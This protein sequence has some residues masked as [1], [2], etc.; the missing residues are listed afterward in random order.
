MSSSV[1]NSAASSNYHAMGNVESYPSNARF[2]P[3]D[4]DKSLSE[5]DSLNEDKNLLLLDLQELTK[6]KSQREEPLEKMSLKLEAAQLLGG[7]LV[8]AVNIFGFPIGDLG[9]PLVKAYIF[10]NIMWKV[11]SAFAYVHGC[12]KESINIRRQ[13]ILTPI[14]VQ[15]NFALKRVA[16]IGIAMSSQLPPTLGAP[17]TLSFGGV[18]AFTGEAFF[19]MQS[20]RLLIKDS[21]RLWYWD[22]WWGRG[23]SSKANQICLRQ[24]FSAAIQRQKENFESWDVQ[25]RLQFI[26]KVEETRALEDPNLRMGQF[27]DLMTGVAQPSL[28]CVSSYPPVIQMG[29]LEKIYKIG[30]PLFLAYPVL[31]LCVESWKACTSA[32][33]WPSWVSVI[34]AGMPLSAVY[35]AVKCGHYALKQFRSMWAFHQGKNLFNN[36]VSPLKFWAFKGGSLALCT[37]GAFGML[38]SNDC[39]AYDLFL[40]PSYF[41]Y[42]LTLYVFVVSF[43]ATNIFIDYG[44]E[45]ALLATRGESRRNQILMKEDFDNLLTSIQD[46]SFKD[47]THVISHVVTQENANALQNACGFTNS[48]WNPLLNEQEDSI[49]QGNTHSTSQRSRCRQWCTVL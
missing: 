37:L 14:P 19:R 9:S 33:Q 42:P 39:N 25:K 24:V 22:R 30:G 27:I 47:L 6:S 35:L 11:W 20:M 10:C 29:T 46:V 5:A 7:G 18:T 3:E 43:T 4:D 8:T 16:E 12:L 21:E 45:K 17:G 26:H 28:F 1:I 41:C 32:L 34:F 44:L 48:N 15:R 49:E 13:F 31:G 38:Q 40:I 36:L 2:P 23:R